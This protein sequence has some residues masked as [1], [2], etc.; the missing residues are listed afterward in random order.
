MKKKLI[1]LLKENLRI[2]VDE[3]WVS[4]S[5]G[6]TRTVKRVQIFYGDVEISSTSSFD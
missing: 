2:E 5:D 4:T 1:E 6:Q 3:D